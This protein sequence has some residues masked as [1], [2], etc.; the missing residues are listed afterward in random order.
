MRDLPGKRAV[1]KGKVMR[2]RGRPQSSNIRDMRGRSGRVARP[3]QI[4]IPRNTGR[5]RLPFPRQRTYLPGGPR[6][7]RGG[8]G[9]PASGG[10][11]R[12][13]LILVGL[14][15]L[16]KMCGF[17]PLDMLAGGGGPS[18]GGILPDRRTSPTELPR[19]VPR[20]PTGERPTGERPAGERPTPQGR[21]ST[22]DE[23]KQFIGVVLAETE[24]VWHGIFRQSGQRYPEPELV[25]F[26]RVIR[27]ACGSASSATGPFYC[28]ADR[29]VYLDT[30]FF[31]TLE[32]QFGAYGDFAKAY[33]IAH[34]VGHHVQNVLGVLPRF[35]RMRQNMRETESNR[36]SVRV[37]LQADCYAGVWA[38]YTEKKGL[39]EKG[40]LEEALNAA[41]QI[42]DDAIQRR[43]Q[44]YVV[45][46]SFNHGTSRQRRDWFYRGFET[47]KVAECDTGIFR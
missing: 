27:S 5:P 23:V 35:N 37:E 32:R 17:N 10:S 1:L 34:E 16:L 38:H 39:L 20:N 46:E 25:L 18:N 24:S 19:P 9:A 42:G 4:R 30:S 47:G 3:R 41:M 21:V 12:I 33:V 13:L 28:P 44:G 22:D 26:S 45:P 31:H 6:I 40:D 43:T 29:K 11:F 14:F 15:F 7:P 2:W 8:Q 36:M